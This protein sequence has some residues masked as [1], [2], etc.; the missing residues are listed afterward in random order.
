MAFVSFEWHLWRL[1]DSIMKLG[2]SRT[3]TVLAMVGLSSRVKKSA[4]TLLA[5]M[6][7]LGIFSV[8]LLLWN[9]SGSV[10]DLI[11]SH[12]DGGPSL[13]HRNI[14]R[15]IA[16]ADDAH[17]RVD[18]HVNLEE[19]VHILPPEYLS[20]ALDTSQLVA[21]KWWDPRATGVE[22]GSGSVPAPL[23]DLDRARLDTLVRALAPAF[24]RVGGSE[25][26]KVYYDMS[27]G[28]RTASPPPGYDSVLTRR[29]WDEL[30]GFARRNRLQLVFTLNAGPSARDGSGQW[31]SDNAT[32]LL[33]YTAERGYPVA[34][35][36]LGNELN[37]FG[38]L[39]GLQH[40][41]SP[42]QYDIDLQVARRSIQ[43]FLPEARVLGQGSAVWPLLGEPLSVFFGFTKPYLQH[44][45]D[46]IDAV[47]WHYYPQQSRRG[48]VASRRATPTRMLRPENLDEVVFWARRM[49]A[50][51]DRYAPEKPLW[52]GETGNAQFGGEPGVSDTYIGGLWWL[53]QLGVLAR[54]RHD[55]VIRQTLSGMNYGM[56]DAET[57]EPNPDYWNSLLWKRLMGE[58]VHAVSLN[59]QDPLVRVYAH[60]TAASRRQGT[61]LLVINLSPA[62]PVTIRLPQFAG[63]GFEVFSVATEDVLGRRVMVNGSDL[64]LGRDDAVPELVPQ[65]RPA[66]I[67]PAVEVGPLAYCFVVV[68]CLSHDSW[69]HSTA[70]PHAWI[71]PGPRDD[72]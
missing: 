16:G 31:R 2:S 52:L 22:L 19:P 30:N 42:K 53:D 72:T 14:S 36:E 57:L 62:D 59:N 47:A 9:G 25:A 43:R 28:G 69:A 44:S 60:S 65:V 45:H 6:V 8:H 15:V 40:R 49:R 34:A 7:T 70:T 41:V 27:A 18:V 64:T 66:S 55:V 11:R 38:F 61:T 32:E 33:R 51:R 1:C 63:R 21:G 13:V 26:D 4:A 56:I 39:F 67:D 10:V 20:F 17:R 58:Q 50:Y 29:R 48:P 37:A 5:A 46:S 54:E 68:P 24:L 3:D 35:W 23:F 71:G 12:T